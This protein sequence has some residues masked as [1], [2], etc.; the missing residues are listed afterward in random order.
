MNLQPE[1]EKQFDIGQ[2]HGLGQRQEY[3]Q[4]YNQGYNQ[5]Y[6]QEINPELIQ[7]IKNNN[8]KVDNGYYYISRLIKFS[9]NFILT[10]LFMEYLLNN[11]DNFNKIQ[12][13]LLVCVFSSLLLY[14]L[15]TNFPSCFVKL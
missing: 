12:L 9:L 1:I 4:E 15:D 2:D 3:N 10:Y 13:I 5:G 14:I 11:I 6:S 7:L 8:Y